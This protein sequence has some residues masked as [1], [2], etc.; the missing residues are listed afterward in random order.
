GRHARHHA[1]FVEQVRNLAA[2]HPNWFPPVPGAVDIVGGAGGMM[3][4]SPF[5]GDK[6]MIMKTTKACFDEGLIS[7]YCGHGPYHVRML[8]P[9]G[10]LDEKIWPE[11]FRI[12]ERALAKVANG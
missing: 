1:L 5:G 9:L 10:V 2:K 8:P 11:A 4:F 7:L 6:A 3:R 12:I